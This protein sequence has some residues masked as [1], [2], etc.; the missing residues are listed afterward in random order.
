MMAVYTYFAT[1]A[2]THTYTL[3]T[4]G[5]AYQCNHAHISKKLHHQTKQ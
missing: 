1:H 4:S 3:T 5:P 2:R